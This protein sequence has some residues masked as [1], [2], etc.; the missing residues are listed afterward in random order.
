MAG[1]RLGS[2]TTVPARGRMTPVTTTAHRAP[3]VA[4]RPLVLVSA[5]FAVL[6][7]VGSIGYGYHRDELYFLVLGHHPA[8][9]Y[10]DQPPLVP[11]VDGL[12]ARVTGSLVALRL[13]ATLAGAGVVLL[14]GLIARELGGDRRAQVLA[15]ASAACGAIV[16]A[17][18]HLATT[19]ALD[20]L[21]WATASWLTVRALV[22]GGPHWLLVGAVVG[23]A[24]ETKLLIGLLV[25]GLLVGLATVGPREPLRDP[26]LWAAALVALVLWVPNLWWQ[27][28]NGLPQLDM[29]GA[30]AAGSSSGTSDPRWLV[31]AMQL[32]LVSPTLVPVWVAGLVRLARH[33]GLRPWRAFAVAYAVVLL[34]VILSGGKGYYVAGLYPVLLAAGA[35]AVVAWL[36]R[37]ARVARWS[38]VAAMLGL[39][40]VVNVTLFLPV[41]PADRL[42]GTPVQAVNYDAGEQVGWPE[43]AEVVGTAYAAAVEDDPRTVVLAGN[44]GEAGAVD[45]YQ[46]DIPVYSGHNSLYPLGPPPSSTS[47]VIALGYPEKQLS[48]WFSEVDRVGT[49]QND[50]GVENDEWGRPVYLCRDPTDSWATLWPLMRNLG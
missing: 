43:L 38:A 18:S 49:V 3:P 22:R 20:V 2:W 31:P 5:A 48:E 6:L 45:R 44:Y 15:A 28:A 47:T 29:A 11:L 4:W 17:G 34:L 39:S 8:A 40:L 26:W 12:V 35:P 10:V 24:L 1:T 41:V 16:L 33:P 37:R 27:V 14:T 25:T 50:A 46:P 36:S 23:V 32:V 13:P 7:L 9:G 19:T 42:Q 21:W 30:I